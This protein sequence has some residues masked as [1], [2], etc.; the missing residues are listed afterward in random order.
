ML[1]RSPCGLVKVDGADAVR[2]IVE[3]GVDNGG[4]FRE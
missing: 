1:V 4:G 2:T 3:A